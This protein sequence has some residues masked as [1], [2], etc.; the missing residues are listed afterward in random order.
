[1]LMSYCDEVIDE[2][3]EV[4]VAVILVSREMVWEQVKHKFIR[5]T[6][7]RLGSN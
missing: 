2:H 6:D 4:M 3:A 7:E 5:Q 1:M